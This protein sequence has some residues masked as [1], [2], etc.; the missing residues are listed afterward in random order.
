VA[1]DLQVRHSAPK[2]L[3]ASTQGVRHFQPWTRSKDPPSRSPADVRAFLTSLAVDR[4]VSAATQN[5]ACNALFFLYRH[6]LHKGC[7]N[8]EGVSRAKRKLSVPVVCSRDEIQAMLQ[9]LPT[10]YD[11]AVKR[12]SGGGLRLSEC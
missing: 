1:N 11:L 5:Q 6:G 2:P 4:E 12:L 7:G 9:H 10:P 3:Q 8:V